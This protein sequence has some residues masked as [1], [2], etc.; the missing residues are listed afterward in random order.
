MTR[1]KVQHS[2][3]PKIGIEL[4]I[5]GKRSQE[6]LP[7]VLTEVSEAGYAGVEAGNLLSI[8]PEKEL[9]E[10]LGSRKLA[11]AGVHVGY[12]ELTETERLASH[13]AYLKTMGGHY[14]ICSGVAEGQGLER[15]DRA[16]ETFNRA[17][18]R[19]RKEGVTF[20]YHNH[21]W[22]FE[23]INGVKGIHRLA[24]KTD[25]AL[26]K[27]NIDVYWVHVGGERPAEF[28][29]RYRNR[30]GYFHFKDG[31]KG[32]FAELGRGEVD[33]VGSKDAALE[34]GADW[35]IA[36]QDRTDL[37]TLESITISRDYLRKLGL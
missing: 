29:R 26:V 37:P 25:P 11:V 34:V 4:I 5:F 28:V 15:Y 13:L 30:G 33:L 6:D 22:E 27:F 7:G 10:L 36:E 14:L 35:I 18:E 23:A 20:C 31:K 8:K 24:E 1:A 19:C 32:S 17:G 21:A 9:K 12:R 3:K 2:S 16:A